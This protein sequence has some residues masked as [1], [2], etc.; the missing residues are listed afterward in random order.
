M[1]LLYHI[2]FYFTTICNKILNILET[3]MVFQS[4][5]PDSSFQHTNESITGQGHPVLRNCYFFLII[6]IYNVRQFIF[7]PDLRCID[8]LYHLNEFFGFQIAII[9]DQDHFM[10]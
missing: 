9:F 6:M 10:E 4:D 3:A 7:C 2:I 8:F 5:S 1:L